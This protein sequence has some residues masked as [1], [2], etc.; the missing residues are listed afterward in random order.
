VLN[1]CDALDGIRDGVIDDPL[2]CKFDPAT[3]LAAKMCANDVNGDGC[4]TARQIETIESIYAGAADSKGTLIF[5]G[6]A[7]GSE[8]GWA[9]HLIP[10]AGNRQA[11]AA[12]PLTADRMNYLFYDEDPGVTPLN[13]TDLTYAP[14]KTRN[15]PE[16]G[17]WEFNPDDW[18]A[19][20][21]AKVSSMI[22]AVDPNL[23]DFLLRRGGKLVIYHGWGDALIPAEPTLDYYKEV[24]LT[25]FASD[26][27][28]AR[29]HARLFM[30]PGMDHCSGGPAPDEW[31]RLTP[32]VDWVEKG[33][34]PDFLTAAHRSNG[35]VDN[36]RKVCAYPQQAA[37]TGPAGG[38]NDRA[39]WVQANFS[40]QSLR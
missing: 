38:Q 24:V 40:C 31:D 10:H 9:R 29:N 18:T 35:K 22:D 39:N 14:N 2:A 36:E 28:A 37:Y 13:L 20:K 4:F 27:A 30:I 7:P 33:A 21:G 34:A 17:W 19:G 8:Y 32:V 16:Y 26:V 6:R 11:P 12:L 25:T 1:A 23:S 5:K 15:P 3:E